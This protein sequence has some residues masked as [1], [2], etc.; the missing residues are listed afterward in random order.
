MKMDEH[1]WT[2]EYKDVVGHPR[3]S[4]TRVLSDAI[5]EHMKRILCPTDLSSTGDHA[6]SGVKLGGGGADVGGEKDGGAVAFDLGQ[7]PI[8]AAVAGHDI[9]QRERADCAADHG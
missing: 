8:G 3:G 4:P 1:S 9:A 5:A 2:D 6:I 7:E